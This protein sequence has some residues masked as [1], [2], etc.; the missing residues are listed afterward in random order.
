MQAS[1][2]AISFSIESETTAATAASINASSMKLNA[3][4]DPT[5]EL[6]L[7]EKM[8][9]LRIHVLRHGLG[10]AAASASAGDDAS[11]GGGSDDF[12][13]LSGGN[14]SDRDGCS[15]RAIVWKVLLGE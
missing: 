4:L 9:Q 10:G 11:G 14:P 7:S 15:T 1:A 3:L 6:P 5:C 2:L 13:P 8:A 12:D